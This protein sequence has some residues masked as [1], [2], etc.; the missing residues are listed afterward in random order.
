M[1]P[2]IQYYNLNDWRKIF[3]FSPEYAKAFRTWIESRFRGAADDT[4]VFSLP[5][6]PRAGRTFLAFGVSTVAEARKL[7][8]DEVVRVRG[9]GESTWREIRDRLEIVGKPQ[10]HGGAE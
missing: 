2:P 5:F 4:N 3:G 8:H 1:S 10:V 6:S 7:R 9:V